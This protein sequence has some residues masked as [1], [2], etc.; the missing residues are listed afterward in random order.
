MKKAKKNDKKELAKIGGIA[1]FIASLCCVTPIVIVVFG[2]GTV[3]FAAG[4]G[5]A[6]YYQY[7]WI[8]IGFGLFAMAVAYILYLRQ[9]GICTLDKAKKERQKIINQVIILLV[10]G[11]V[12]Y[13]IFNYII[14]EYI[15]YWLGIWELPW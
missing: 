8:F 13:L 14:L 4:L 3:S 2:L 6:L 1:A 10:L 15:G 9:K 7:R 11:I 12:M 5:N